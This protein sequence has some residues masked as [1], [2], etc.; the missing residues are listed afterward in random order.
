MRTISPPAFGVREVIESFSHGPR[1]N[2]LH[3]LV[4]DFVTAEADYVAVLRARAPHLLCPF[5]AGLSALA[6]ADASWAYEEHFRSTTGGGRTFYESIRGV[7]EPCGT[8]RVRK[9]RVVD[10]YLPRS[11]YPAYAIQPTNLVP[12]CSDC[13]DRKLDEVPSP[14]RVHFLH[15]YFDHLGDDGWLVARVTDGPGRPVAFSVNRGYIA[16]PGLEQRAIAHMEYFRLSTAFAKHAGD[17]L[18]DHVYILDRFL[19]N[20]GPSKVSDHLFE[21]SDSSRAGGAHPWIAASLAA[22]A[23]DERFCGGAWNEIMWKL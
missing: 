23:A 5:P 10:H 17:F 13:N 6:A 12:I 11:I 20:H 1:V 9:A 22:W 7:D 2:G 18:V 21:L 16:N 19:A 4:A 3:R 14:A 15:P 8:C